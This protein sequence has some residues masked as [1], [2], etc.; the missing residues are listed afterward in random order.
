MNNTTING[1][2]DPRSGSPILLVLVCACAKTLLFFAVERVMS[3]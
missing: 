2:Q 3:S 1:Y